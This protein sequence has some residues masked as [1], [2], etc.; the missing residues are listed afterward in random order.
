MKTAVHSPQSN[1]SERVNQ[2]VL[3]AIRA[4]LQNDHREWDMNLSNIE[5]S[6][7]TSWHSATGCRT[8]FA[9]FGQNMF[10][11]GPDY[12]LARQLKALDDN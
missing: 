11:C 8:F 2:S 12:K 7:R 6:L 4:Y 1:A 9:L 3:S 10:T 5:L